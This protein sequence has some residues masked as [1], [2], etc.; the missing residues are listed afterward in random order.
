M[1]DTSPELTREQVTELFRRWNAE[2]AL[3]GARDD[4]TDADQADEFIRIANELKNEG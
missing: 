1:P 3:A 4:F 2:V